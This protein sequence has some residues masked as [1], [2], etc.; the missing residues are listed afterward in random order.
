MRR[1]IEEHKPW[2]GKVYTF[3]VIDDQGHVVEGGLPSIEDCRLV[4]DFKARSE[5]I[6]NLHIEFEVVIHRKK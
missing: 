2:P 3:F 6:T 5:N 4:I 1:P